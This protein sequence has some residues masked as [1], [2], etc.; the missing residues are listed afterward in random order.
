ME[1]YRYKTIVDS[2]KAVKG[3]GG[4]AFITNFKNSMANFHYHNCIETRRKKTK[5]FEERMTIDK[6]RW[7]PSWGVEPKEA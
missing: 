4:V 1:N 5:Y 3:G 6:E 7:L 2:E